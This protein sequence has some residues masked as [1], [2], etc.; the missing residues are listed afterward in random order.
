LTKSLFSINLQRFKTILPDIPIINRLRNPKSGGFVSNGAAAQLEVDRMKQYRKTFKLLMFLSGILLFAMASC[1][2][3]VQGLNPASWLPGAKPTTSAILAHTSQ[4]Q[5]VDWIKKLSGVEPVTV[6]GKQATITT[7]YDYAMFT[8]QEN[9]RAF[10]YVLEQVQG[11]YNP[12]QIEVNPYPY[13]DAEHSYTWKNLI[14]T[15]PGT[16][17]AQ[18]EVVLSAH[19][20]STVVKEGNA[21]ISAPGADDNGTGVATLLEAARLFSHVRFERTVKLIWFTGEEHNLAGSQAYVA[22]HPTQNIVAMVNMDMF[23]YDANGDRCFELHVGTNP[24]ADAVGQAFVRSILTYTLNLNVEYVTN[25]ATSRSDHESFWEKG[26]PAVAVMENFLDNSTANGC[27][28]LDASPWY[29][30]PEDTLDKIN[31]P[32]GFDLAR[33]GLATVSDLAVP[34]QQVKFW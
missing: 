14:V 29:H 17:K 5:W 9:A 21:M 32:F 15:I 2:L 10:D 24:A 26:V 28:G 6:G 34:V 11:W 3:P 16:T 13:I 30:R 31:L 25:N 19:L 27:K 23:G 4:G 33:A 8:G 1:N 20:D 7:R 12:G 22:S 18:E